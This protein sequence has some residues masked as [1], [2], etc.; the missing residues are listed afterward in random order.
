MN[1]NKSTYTIH[2]LREQAVK[3]QPKKIKDSAV[4]TAESRAIRG[5][6]PLKSTFIF[7]YSGILSKLTSHGIPWILDCN[8]FCQ[9]YFDI[10]GKKNEDDRNPRFNICSTNSYLYLQ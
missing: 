9:F 2:C 4:N 3:H 5:V 8:I 6:Q 7:I 1:I 10:D